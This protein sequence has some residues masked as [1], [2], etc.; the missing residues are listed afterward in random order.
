M[1]LLRPQR[2][3]VRSTFELQQ[4]SAGGFPPKDPLSL[5]LIKRLHLLLHELICFKI[6]ALLRK[7]ENKRLRADRQTLSP[8]SIAPLHKPQ[9]RLLPRN[10]GSGFSKLLTERWRV[11]RS[12]GHLECFHWVDFCVIIILRRFF[13]IFRFNW[14]RS[15]LSVNEGHRH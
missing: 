5:N 9:E 12:F 8:T 13:E 6:A 2:L 15:V 10:F 1:P 14:S 3:S 7:S 11:D 4:R